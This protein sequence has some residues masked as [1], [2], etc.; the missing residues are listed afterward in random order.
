MCG[1]A[2]G[3]GSILAP[4]TSIESAACAGALAQNTIA[5]VAAKAKNREIRISV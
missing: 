4:R 2:I 3:K 1:I 5:T